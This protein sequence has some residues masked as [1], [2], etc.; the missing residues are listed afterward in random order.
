MGVAIVE[1]EHDAPWSIDMDRVACCFVT[2]QSM[3]T[4][5]GKVH[6]V[7]CGGRIKNIQTAQDAFVK[8]YTSTFECPFPIR[9]SVAVCESFHHRRLSAFA[10]INCQS[11]GK[12]EMKN[13]KKR[14]TGPL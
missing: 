2:S 9:L 4:E 11:F 10:Y 14:N 8:T 12:T 7:R 1:F 13:C 3:K 5:A 6:I